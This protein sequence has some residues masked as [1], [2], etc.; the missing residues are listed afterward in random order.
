MAKSTSTALSIGGN[1]STGGKRSIVTPDSNVL[2][3]IIRQANLYV[4]KYALNP[5]SAVPFRVMHVVNGKITPMSTLQVLSLVYKSPE[6][7]TSYLQ[8]CYVSEYA[9]AYKKAMLAGSHLP[10]FDT[11]VKSLVTI[12]NMESESVMK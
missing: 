5:E 11:E 6:V 10:A 2:L 1:L 8:V 4:S 7:Q 9:S 12:E 3:S